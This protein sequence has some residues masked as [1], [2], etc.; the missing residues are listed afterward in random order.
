MN[1]LS[2]EKDANKLY[3]KMKEQVTETWNTPSPAPVCHAE[4]SVSG[5]LAWREYKAARR[6]TLGR[7][8][9]R[10]LSVYRLF[11]G[12]G[13]RPRNPHPTR[14]MGPRN[15][16]ARRRSAP[17]DQTSSG[18]RTPSRRFR[19]GGDVAAAGAARGLRYDGATSP[20]TVIVTG[21]CLCNFF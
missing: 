10:V 16:P 15:R 1:K 21:W 18:I 13:P 11:V 6:A 20:G 19:L 4:A 17:G 9:E 7:S 8:S 14:L 5:S 12:R 3:L 2:G